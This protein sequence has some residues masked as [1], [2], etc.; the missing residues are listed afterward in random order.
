MRFS[1]YD[2]Y[3][4][5]TSPLVTVNNAPPGSTV[6]IVSAQGNVLAAAQADN[7]GTATLDIG[8]YVMPL[9]ANINVYVLGVLVGS[10]PSSVPIFGG[11]VYTVSLNPGGIVPVGIGTVYTS[12]P[13]TTSVINPNA[14]QGLK[15]T[16]S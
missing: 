16:F 1:V 8:M 5:T 12:N 7:S 2:N 6:K 10:T 4:A 14:G 11:D 3:Y 9:K 13:A 15:L